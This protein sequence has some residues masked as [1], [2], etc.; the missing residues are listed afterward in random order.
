MGF[1]RRVAGFLGLAKDDLKDEES[2]TN[3]D[4]A[5]VDPN[6]YHQHL[7]RKGFSVAVPVAV[8]R[9]RFGPVLV[10]CTIGNGGI[11]GLRWYARRLRVDEDG[12]V[13]DEF[14]SETIVM[15]PESLEQHERF[16]RY[17]IKYNAIPAKVRSQV[18]GPDGR[19][20]QSVDYKGKLQ[21]V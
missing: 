15:H 16:P 7:T 20:L 19:V 11:Q 1:F 17:E 9:P 3:P 10:P 14:L 21:W 2:N 5:Y 4:A 13:A 18:L 6:H 8:D 12:D